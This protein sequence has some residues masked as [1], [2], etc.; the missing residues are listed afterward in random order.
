MAAS[1]VT[2]AK[3]AA[4]GTA[5]HRCRPAAASPYETLNNISE[6]TT[7]RATTARARQ[8]SGASLTPVVRR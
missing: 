8:P 4:I 3:P 2:R 1:Q 7:A 5:I 6:A